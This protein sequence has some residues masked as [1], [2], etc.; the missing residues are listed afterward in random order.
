MWFHREKTS[1][2][3]EQTKP[4]GNNETTQDVA[5]IQK[6]TAYISFTPDGTITYANELFCSA[7]GYSP[8]EIIGKHHKMFCEPTY[9]ASQSYKDHWHALASGSSVSGT[10]HRIKR[11]GS[12]IFISADYFP[13]ADESGKIVKVIKIARDVTQETEK[14][15]SQKAIL[16][17]LDRS[18]ATIEF[19]PDGTIIWANQNFLDTIGYSLD[20]I[21]GKHHKMFCSEEFYRK[22]PDFWRELAQGQFKTG[23]FKRR[24]ANGEIIWLEASYNPIYDEQGNV[25]KVIKFAS[26]ITERINNVLLSIEMAST[27]SEETSHITTMAVDVLREAVATSDKIVGEVNSA[28]KIGAELIAQSKSI[29]EIV[30]TI[31]GIADQT[32]LLALNAAIEAARAGESGRGFAVVADEVRKLAKRTS[33]A[34]TQIAQVISSNTAMISEMDS[35]L[36]QVNGI[37]LQGQDR[38]SEVQ[39]G[40]EDVKGGVGRFV[41]TVQRLQP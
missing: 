24:H 12:D 6:Y 22:Y 17:A 36:S 10:F 8:D 5:A 26:D 34:T 11:D 23:R 27:T 37:A 21:E 35:S 32:N 30:V 19:H 40:L 16:E 29:D 4:A 14:R 28:A 2:S 9:V 31:Q 7:M 33:E 15:L 3:T 20:E 18:L 39:L 1:Y 25:I 41:E 38:I 13:V